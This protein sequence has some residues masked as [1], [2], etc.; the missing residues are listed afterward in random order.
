MQYR[1]NKWEL[2]SF[3]LFEL[4]LVHEEVDKS[5]ALYY[6]SQGECQHIWAC[7]SLDDDAL[8]AQARREFKSP[9]YSV[10]MNDI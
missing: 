6:S 10:R 7:L 3:G 4:E 8:F 1:G 5:L 2:L 9:I